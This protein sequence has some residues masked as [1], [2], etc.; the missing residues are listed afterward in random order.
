M[1]WP[2]PSYDWVQRAD[3]DGT[4][5]EDQFTVEAFY[6]L[7]LA[8]QLTV[9]PSVEYI[10]SPALSPKD[11]STWVLGVRVRLAL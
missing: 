6:R 7:Q 2:D 3:L 11:D 10:D 4:D 1:Y 5:I 8:P 9:T